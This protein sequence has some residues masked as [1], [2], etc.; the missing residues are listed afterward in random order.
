[1][2]KQHKLNFHPVRLSIMILTV[3]VITV[4]TIWNNIRISNNMTN[5]AKLIS[6]KSIGKLTSTISRNMSSGIKIHDSTLT[7]IINVLVHVKDPQNRINYINDFSMTTPDITYGIV[8]MSGNMQIIGHDTPVNV[9]N[10]DFFKKS[11]YEKKSVTTTTSIM[12]SNQY[13]IN[14]VIAKPIIT[15]GSDE[16]SSVICGFINPSAI[17]NS[18]E[19]DTGII[20]VLLTTPDNSILSYT[21]YS[22]ELEK[23]LTPLYDLVTDPEFSEK[24]ISVSEDTADAVYSYEENNVIRYIYHTPNVFS[25]WSL[26]TSVIVNPVYTDTSYYSLYL[27]LSNILFIIVVMVAILIYIVPVSKEARSQRVA[28]SESMM[29]AKLS[30]ELKT[31]LN[32]IMGVSEILSKSNLKNGQLREVSYISEAGN[33]LLAM[34]NDILDM[35]KIEAGKLKLVEEE[36]EF[37]SIIYDLT[38]IASVRLNNKPV[39]FI[40]KISPH[41]PRYMIGDM[42]RVR[43]LL[44]NIVTNAVKYTHQGYIMITIDCE[45]IN[46]A[47]FNLIV[48]VKDTGIGITQDNIDHLFDSYSRFD[49]KKNSKI[50]GTGLG[51]TIV[52]QFVDLMHGTISVKSEYGKGSEFTV[53]IM[54]R[55][56]K[57]EPL[58]PKYE[59]KK[60]YKNMLILEPSPILKKYYSD[61][62]DQTQVQYTITADN[63]EFSR[64]LTAGSYDL[65]LA[66][67]ATTS[68]LTEEGAIPDDTHIITLVYNHTELIDEDYTVFVPLF[69]LQIYSYLSKNKK[70]YAKNY[71]IGKSFFIHPMPDKHVLIVD[72]NDMNLQVAAAV[73]RPYKMQIDCAESGEKALEMVQNTDYDIIFMDHMMPGMDGEETLHAIRKLKGHKYKTIPVIVLTANASRGA[74]DVFIRMGFQDFLPKPLEIRSLNN[75]LIKWLKPPQNSPVI[76][77]RVTDEDSPDADNNIINKD[78]F[79]EEDCG[80]IDFKEGIARIGSMPIYV[81]TLKNFYKTIQKKPETIKNAFPDDMKTFVI[82]VHGLK[83]VAATVSANKLARLS[84][85][86][87]NK[88]K[89]NDIDGIAPLLDDYFSYMQQIEECVKK[90]IEKYS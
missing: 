32:T 25:D 46:Q 39:E 28:E 35:S 78:S 43:Q 63:Y 15:S 23:K 47:S 36:Y 84:L 64:L 6:Y 85:D 44:S 67:H 69:S 50:E 60:P 61:C 79:D 59:P 51:M 8:D 5:S 34:I 38:T 66:D 30:H 86:L 82:E 49:S 65:I 16:V 19:F 88:G 62:L 31:P 13:S 7:S 24:L 77:Y 29:L 4:F 22:P 10:E 48:S 20:Q 80:E 55:M 68:M 70:R 14:I 42:L 40:T 27:T 2:I 12:A 53:K 1:M 37:E 58:I 75:K 90:F 21:K 56:A 87:E 45:F 73:M 11:A 52:K 89:A 41:V 26:Y 57:T 72:D 83:G 74:K 9:A 71:N 81:K 54:Q 76:E 3:L 33:N 17:V 18:Y